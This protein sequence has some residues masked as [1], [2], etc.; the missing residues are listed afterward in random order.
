MY[1]S[2]NTKYYN[3]HYI[4][5]NTQ[6]KQTIWWFDKEHQ[7]KTLKLN[8]L[9]SKNHLF[10]VEIQIFSCALKKLSKIL[11]IWVLGKYR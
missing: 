7:G 2:N 3:I 8:D 11:W 1:Y 5:I 4:V 10:Y 9:M 6:G